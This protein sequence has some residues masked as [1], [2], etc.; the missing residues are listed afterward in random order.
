MDTLRASTYNKK[1]NWEYVM[2]KQQPPGLKRI[3][4][5]TG[6]SFAGLKA[7]FKNEAAFRQELLLIAILVPLALWLGEN[8]LEKAVLIFSLLLVLIVELLNS[9]IESTNDRV[10]QE[11]HEL[12]GRAKDIASAAVALSLL[13]AAIVWLVLLLN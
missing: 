3:I 11:R 12:T 13:N 9:A 4:N 6:Y 2:A 10:S 7:A 8:A 5:A 1:N